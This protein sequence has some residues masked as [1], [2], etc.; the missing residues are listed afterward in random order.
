M[1]LLLGWWSATCAAFSRV[2]W[3]AD[4]C[5]SVISLVVSMMMMIVIVV[6]IIIII[7]VISGSRVVV[8][9]RSA[10]TAT[11]TLNILHCIH[12]LWM[13][14]VTMMWGS[15]PIRRTVSPYI[16]IHIIIII[17]PLMLLLWL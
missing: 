11:T 15:A 8:F 3:P 5:G 13:M 1:V 10:A 2:S 4:A 6:D 16:F 12:I 17:W 7:V 9:G 14:M